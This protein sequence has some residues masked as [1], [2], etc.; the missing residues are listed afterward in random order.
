VGLNVKN[1]FNKQPYYDPNGW[2]GYNH[3]QDLFGRQFALSA[4]YKFFDA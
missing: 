2:E 3:S 1:A 4:S